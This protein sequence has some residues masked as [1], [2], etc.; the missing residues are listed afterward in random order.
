MVPGGL[1]PSRYKSE[2]DA[3]E[4]VDGAYKLGEILIQWKIVS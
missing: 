4:E 1:H 3:S 2:N